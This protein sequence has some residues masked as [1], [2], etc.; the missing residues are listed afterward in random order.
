MT[1]YTDSRRF[2]S[3]NLLVDYFL[4]QISPAFLILV[5]VLV[6]GLGCLLTT[7]TKPDGLVNVDNIRAGRLANVWA[8]TFGVGGRCRFAKAVNP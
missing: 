7:L 3:N 1:V 4:D 8:T 2:S 6:G 5:C